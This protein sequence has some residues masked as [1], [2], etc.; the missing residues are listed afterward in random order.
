MSVGFSGTQYT[1]KKH[2]QCLWGSLVVLIIIFNVCGMS[3]GLQYNKK[4][5]LQRLWGSLGLHIY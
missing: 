2:L 4:N 3:V 1:K 5:H